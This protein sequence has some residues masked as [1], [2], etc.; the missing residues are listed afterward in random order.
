VED[1]DPDEDRARGGGTRDEERR[2]TGREALWIARS[3]E[4]SH[5]Q[6]LVEGGHVHHVALAGR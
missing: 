4:L 1:R 3:D 6:I 5:H 2:E